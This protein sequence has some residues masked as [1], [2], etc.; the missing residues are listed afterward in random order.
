MGSWT[1]RA[2]R[3]GII[4]VIGLLVL[5]A[6]ISATPPPTSTAA[7]ATASAAT[8]ISWE[9]TK[10]TF[11]DGRIYYVRG[12]TCAP[13]GSAACGNYLDRKRTLVTFVHGATGLEDRETAA[14]WLQ[15]M[16]GWSNETIFAF[17][18]SKDG[19]KTFDAGICCTTEPVDD[20]GYL[21][22]IVDDVDRRWP[23]N[24]RRVGVTGLSNGGM[25]ALRAACER[26]DVFRA[27]VALAGIYDGG[28]DEGRVRI[29][30]WHGAADP[31]VPLEGGPV[32]VNGVE[33]TLPPVVSL[34]QRLAEGS[35]YELRVIP[36][37]GHTMTWDDHHRATDWLIGHLP[38]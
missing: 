23:V 5:V 1:R 8:S 37:R 4:G 27:A 15:G 34:S 2:R 24:R 6:G 18:V 36:G 16:N 25:L 19:T 20:V 7:G 28:C 38:R 30:Q 22:R 26:P 31:T 12:P 13:A 35:T 29:A 11:A 9:T 21:T 33:R 17:A 3:M 10:R 14:R 32:N